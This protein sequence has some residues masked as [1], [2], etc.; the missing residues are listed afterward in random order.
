MC[1]NPINFSLDYQIQKR[2]VNII[3]NSKIS[4]TSSLPF[5]RPILMAYLPTIMDCKCF[6]DS[7]SPFHEEVANTPLGHL[8]EH[9][10]INCMAQ[11]KLAT[12][13]TAIFNGRTYWHA[14]DPNPQTFFIRISCKSYDLPI[15]IKSL[16]HAINI[17]NK[18]M[19]S[20]NT[21]RVESTPALPT[22][23]LTTTR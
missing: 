5:T 18:I 15:F 1:K 2:G 14:N 16:P 23:S 4:S 9:I 21:Q 13:D 20:A 3:F 10:L 6:N 11:T 17:M 22:S 19:L 12:Y 8:F 7:N